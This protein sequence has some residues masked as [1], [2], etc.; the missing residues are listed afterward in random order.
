MECGRRV[1]E[2]GGGQKIGGKEGNAGRERPFIHSLWG[3]LGDKGSL[4]LGEVGSR[5]AMRAFF[6][7]IMRCFC[8]RSVLMAPS[9]ALSQSL[10]SALSWARM[11]MPS[12]K[13]AVLT[14]NWRGSGPTSIVASE[15]TPPTTGRH[16]WPL[17]TSSASCLKYRSKPPWRM[18]KRSFSSCLMPVASMVVER[19]V[20][21]DFFFVVVVVVVVGFCCCF[22]WSS[23]ARVVGTS[24]VG[25]GVPAF[26]SS[27][28]PLANK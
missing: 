11:V 28:S 10:S 1:V 13:T 6:C 17:G 25:L 2:G 3:D 24:P 7:W 15:A 22:C 16:S 21:A 14:V 20:V 8:L 23:L 4:D 9:M 18:K 26:A 19:R 12:G 5:R 27:S